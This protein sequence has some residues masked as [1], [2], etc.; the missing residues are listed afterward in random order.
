MG[1]NCSHD[2]F[3]GAYSA[4]N[5]L[6]QA[7]AESMG[8]SFPPH[9]DPQFEIKENWYWGDGY[10]KESHPGLFIFMSHSD[11]DGEIS[12]TDCLAVADDLEKLLP[13][14]PGDN[15]GGG[16]IQSQ[17]GYQNVLTKFINGCRAAAKESESLL[18]E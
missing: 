12:P 8:G 10:G 9:D 15:T 7:V 5:R 4:F 6:R 11:C 16:H 1:L 13:L 18:F 14:L 2:A 3:D 17:G